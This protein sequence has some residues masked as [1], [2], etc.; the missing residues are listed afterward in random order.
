MNLKLTWTRETGWTGMSRAARLNP[1]RWLTGRD[2][3]ASLTVGCAIAGLLQFVA[4]LWPLP[5]GVRGALPWTWVAAPLAAGGL[6]RLGLWLER[7]G[8]PAACASRFALVGVLN[9]LID[10]AVLN[11]FLF[12]TG[13]TRGAFFALFKGLSFAVAVTNS[14]AWN[15]HW[16]FASTA[17]KPE[18]RKSATQFSLFVGVTLIGLGMNAG[19]AVL[20][21]ESVDPMAGLS[22]LAWANVAAAVAL[23]VSSFWNFLAYY[24]FVFRD[25]AGQLTE[26]P[27]AHRC[28]RPTPLAFL[29]PR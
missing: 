23:A 19:V 18:K 28:S 3:V 16:S 8:F 7:R 26:P 15:K 9:T 13:I 12:S 2:A 11:F 24:G 14:Y 10:F 25:S 4:P 5:E 20:W 22:P 1:G 27:P 17:Q 29:R 6:V 21:I